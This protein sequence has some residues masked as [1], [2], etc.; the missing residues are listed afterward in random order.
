MQIN[1]NVRTFAVKK[2][3][4]PLNIEPIP[5]PDIAE[6]TFIHVPTGGVTAPTANPVIRIPPNCIGEIPTAT[7]AGRKTGVSNKIAGLTSIKVPAIKII[8]TMAINIIMG[9]KFMA[10]TYPAT[11]SGI[12]SSAR[13]QIYS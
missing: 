10:T 1:I 9:G 2:G 13:I 7:Q 4:L 3:I 5:K 8:M 6:V 12:L 11:A